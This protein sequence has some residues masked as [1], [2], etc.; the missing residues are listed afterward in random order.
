MK[1]IKITEAH[2]I[3]HLQTSAGHDVRAT[4]VG[5]ALAKLDDSFLN[6]Q[7][8]LDSITDGDTGQIREGVV[9]T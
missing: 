2:G 8:L 3:V 1:T 9:G 6:V 4:G 5:Q 7:D